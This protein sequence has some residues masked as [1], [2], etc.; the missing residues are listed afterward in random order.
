M[1]YAQ[2]GEKADKLSAE[3]PEMTFWAEH[4]PQHFEPH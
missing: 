1:S 4:T 3:H 2:A